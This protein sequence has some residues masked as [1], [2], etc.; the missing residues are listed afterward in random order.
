LHRHLAGQYGRFAF[1]D[2]QAHVQTSQTSTNTLR[3]ALWR[4]REQNCN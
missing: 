2:C 4:G 3:S 1:A